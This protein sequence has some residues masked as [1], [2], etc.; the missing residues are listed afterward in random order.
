[1]N[2]RNTY[3]YDEGAE[4]EYA[5]YE[6]PCCEQGGVWWEDY[7]DLWICDYCFVGFDEWDFA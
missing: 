1:M 4:K 2:E 5:P 7:W 6:C 3:G